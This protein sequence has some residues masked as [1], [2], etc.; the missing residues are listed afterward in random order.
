MLTIQL[1][2]ASVYYLFPKVL[3]PVHGE[4]DVA[5]LLEEKRKGALELVRSPLGIKFLKMM[6]FFGDDRVPIELFLGFYEHA[7]RQNKYSRHPFSVS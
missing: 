3:S 1:F 7:A 6:R 4:S 5:E 2:I